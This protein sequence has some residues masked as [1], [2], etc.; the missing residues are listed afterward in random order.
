MYGPECRIGVVVEEQ[1]GGANL[2]FG[3]LP[4]LGD[5][6]RRSRLNRETIIWK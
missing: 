2:K 3:W 6:W 4:S 1:K 5:K